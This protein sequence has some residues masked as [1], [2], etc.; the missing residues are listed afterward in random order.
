MGVL[1]QNCPKIKTFLGGFILLWF[2]KVLTL[3]FT[4]NG[5]WIQRSL[6]IISY[7][8]IYKC[9]L[10]VFGLTRK[11]ETTGATIE[12]EQKEQENILNF[13]LI[14]M[15]PIAIKLAQLE[16][17]KSLSFSFPM[18]SLCSVSNPIDSASSISVNSVPLLLLPQLPC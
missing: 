9:F 2:C 6:C 7:K 5:L 17:W 8:C 13:H 16:S 12:E 3:S 1:T 4:D 11:E 15:A 18:L 14:L 10:Y